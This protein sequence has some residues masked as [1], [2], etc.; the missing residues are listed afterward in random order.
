[1]S[2]KSRVIA[3]SHILTLYFVVSVALNILGIVSKY[4]IDWSGCVLV[5]FI[6]IVTLTRSSARRSDPE[7]REYRF[8][9]SMPNAPTYSLRAKLRTRVDTLD[10][11]DARALPYC[12]WRSANASMSV[13]SAVRVSCFCVSEYCA[14]ISFQMIDSSSHSDAVC[15]SSDTCGIREA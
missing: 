15:G 12:A 10:R 8:D 3:A 7:P 11:G 9:I 5:F 13:H 14:Y 4:S 2:A 6:S 1:M